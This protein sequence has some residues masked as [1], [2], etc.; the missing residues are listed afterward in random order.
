[1]S[2]EGTDSETNE[3]DATQKGID[4]QS[5]YVV[6]QLCKK[7]IMASRFSNLSNHARRHSVIKKFKCVYCDLQHNEHAK[8]R[9][10]MANM[11][12]DR[13]S[14][15]IDNSWRMKKVWEF[16]LQKCFPH[17]TPNNEPQP[18]VAENDLVLPPSPGSGTFACGIC[19]YHGVDQ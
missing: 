11:H 15:A 14:M 3:G 19:G 1:S 4:Y 5:P 6:C 13:S 10:H 18:V 9:T 7:V 17:Y 8:I 16:L 2:G 12:A